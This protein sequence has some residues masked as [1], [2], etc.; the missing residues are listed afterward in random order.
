VSNGPKL[1][2]GR[3]NGIEGERVKPLGEHLVEVILGSDAGAD[4][5]IAGSTIGQLSS[6]SSTF[7]S[8]LLSNALSVVHGHQCSSHGGDEPL[9][10]IPV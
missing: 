6:S 2:N 1:V 10:V 9:H 8:V 3:A 7:S 5:R 4:V